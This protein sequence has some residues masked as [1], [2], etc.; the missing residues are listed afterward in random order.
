MYQTSLN[1]FLKSVTRYIPEFYMK[2][3]FPNLGSFL[4]SVYKLV[5]PVRQNVTLEILDHFSIWIFLAVTDD[6]QTKIGIYFSFRKLLIKQC[7]F[8]IGDAMEKIEK[9]SGYL[10]SNFWARINVLE[11]PLIKATKS[12][13]N[14]CLYKPIRHMTEFWKISAVSLMYEVKFDK[15]PKVFKILKL[16]S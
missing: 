3:D 6:F 5:V 11:V 9:K 7:H 15:K 12:Q 2:I 14:T 4:F 13:K 8:Q 10:V 16:G 1:P